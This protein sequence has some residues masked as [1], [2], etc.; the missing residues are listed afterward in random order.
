[1]PYI[2][3]D[4]VAHGLRNATKRWAN[5]TPEM[6]QLYAAKATYGKMKKNPEK[7]RAWLVAKF[8]ENRAQQY[9]DS[10]KA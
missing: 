2:D 7:A 5:A 9:L 1:M 3:Y 6:K 8:G 10:W 4:F